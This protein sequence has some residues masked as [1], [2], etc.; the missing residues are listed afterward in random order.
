MISLPEGPVNAAGKIFRDSVSITWNLYKIMIP[1]IVLVKI[2]QE[3]DMIHHVAAPLVPVMQVVGLPGEMGFV[4]AA[5]IA[6]NVYSGIILLIA[7]VEHT[8]LS[9]AQVTVI[10]TMMLMAHALPVELRIAQKS[11]SRLP[12]QAASRLVGAFVLGWLLCQVYS[13]TGT[14]D[15][16]VRIFLSP[17]TSG[18]ALDRSA[19]M[20]ALKEARTLVGIYFIILSLLTGMRLLEHFGII[21]AIN[22]MLSPALAMLGI[23]SGAAT[24]TMI[25]LTLGIAYGGGLIIHEAKSGSVPPKDLFYSMTLM[26]LSHSLVEDTLLMMLVGGHLTGILLGRIV[27][28]LAAVSILTAVCRHLPAGWAERTLWHRPA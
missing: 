20:W 8:P 17:D 18:G 15:E 25:G 28:S 16:P 21:A 4:W 9:T 2:L 26:G 27:F 22:R 7:F 6:N 13:L 12:F 23:G 24:I 3:M 14:L 1:V 11:G 10:C 19:A 5:A